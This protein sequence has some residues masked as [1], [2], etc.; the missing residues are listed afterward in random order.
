MTAGGPRVEVVASADDAVPLLLGE[1]RD[2]LA[3]RRQRRI[4]FATGRT[5]APFLAAVA[6]AIGR[7]ELPPVFAATHLDEY[8]GFGPERDGGMVHE[9]CAACPPFGA[10]LQ[11][12]AFVPVPCGDDPAA[13]AA[14][15]ARLAASGGVG[16]WFVGIGRNGHVAF[17]EPGVPLDRGFH[18]ATLAAATR[19]DARERFAPDA[20]PRFANT[21]GAATLL[22]AERVVLCAF[23][24][25][26]AAAV[27]AALRGPVGEA[28]PAS[29]L[30]RHPNVLVVLDAAA[31]A[32]AGE[33][34]A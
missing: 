32:M 4:G 7:G 9:L 21:A 22:R 2:A 34:S 31:A 13:L 23:G 14:H 18:R 29:V 26:K 20:P 11:Q 1:L 27:R 15:A 5:F 8:L 12:G 30:Q 6:A 19:D 28:C 10:M 3:R 25:A 33:G 17:H 24:A 16:L